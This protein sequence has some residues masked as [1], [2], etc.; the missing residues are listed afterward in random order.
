[1][2]YLFSFFSLGYCTFL[3]AIQGQARQLDQ[4]VEQDLTSSR[5]P[6]QSSPNSQ[7]SSSSAQQRSKRTSTSSSSADIATPSLLEIEDGTGPEDRGQGMGD[8]GNGEED[9][10]QREPEDGN[11]GYECAVS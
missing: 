11:Q 2:F 10:E 8:S 5:L 9:L 4:I 3:S 7:A 1:M 6:L